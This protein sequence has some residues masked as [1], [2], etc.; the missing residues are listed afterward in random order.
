VQAPTQVRPI[1]I[2]ALFFLC[3]CLPGTR[4]PL[5]ERTLVRL[6]EVRSVN[7]RPGSLQE[8][9][10]LPLREGDLLAGRDLVLTAVGSRLDLRIPGSSS[11]RLV[12]GYLPLSSL[13]LA[14]GQ[15][16]QAAR[17][18]GRAWRARP[19]PG[20]ML[21]TEIPLPLQWEGT[22]DSWGFSGRQF[23]GIGGQGAGVMVIL[24]FPRSPAHRMGL[25]PGDV[26]VAAAGGPVRSPADL[27]AQLQGRRQAT[28]YVSRWP[29]IWRGDL[30]AGPK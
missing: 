24:V 30:R 25:R 13:A 5:L 4:D 2:L 20:K 18:Q 21:I 28:L 8:L 1:A 22:R 12:E 29:V 11:P 26:I 23:V 3:A 17:I 14:S 7:L 9:N 15:K 16:V 6:E 27:A 19:G 10:W